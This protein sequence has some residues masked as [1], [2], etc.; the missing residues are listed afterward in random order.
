MEKE[1]IGRKKSRKTKSSYNRQIHST[2]SL[3]QLVCNFNLLENLKKNYKTKRV[4]EIEHLTRAK[5]AKHV[6]SK[7]VKVMI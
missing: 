3:Y 5:E 2:V 1:N 6:S 7:Q 4:A